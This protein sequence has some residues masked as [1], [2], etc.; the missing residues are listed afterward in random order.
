M[1]TLKF[2][3]IL[4]KKT[5]HS[6]KYFA[7]DTTFI[8]SIFGIDCCGK[9]P[10]DRGRNATEISVIVDDLGISYS[11]CAYPANKNDCRILK[12]TF[13]NTFIALKKNIYVYADK[14]YDTRECKRYVTD[15]SFMDGILKKNVVYKKYCRKRNI[16]ENFFSWFKMFRR[17]ILRYEKYVSNYLSFCLM[18]FM[19]ILSNKIHMI[20]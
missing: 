4:N 1:H 10:T 14:A 5:K 19:L 13:E 2:L 18:S 20:V 16:V 15:N 8:K 17:I 6:E 9:N 7:T 3:N 12:P 11:L